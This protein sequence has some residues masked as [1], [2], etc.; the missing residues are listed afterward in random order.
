MELQEQDDGKRLNTAGNTHHFFFQCTRRNSER[1]VESCRVQMSQ[2]IVC[3]GNDQLKLADWS[4]HLSLPVFC[5]RAGRRDAA[6]LAAG[7]LAALLAPVSLPPR[8]PRP[9]SLAVVAMGQRGAVGPP[10][11]V[12]TRPPLSLTTVFVPSFNL[13]F[14]ASN[15]EQPPTGLDYPAIPKNQTSLLLQ[16]P[17]CL[18][19]RF[20][21]TVS[22]TAE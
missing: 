6:Q 21:C 5:L 11:H 8:S 13:C 2:K 15:L 12:N 19:C 9:A 7:A 22:T 16:V 20:N 18:Y 10:P 17:R 4:C 14:K 3:D 1:V